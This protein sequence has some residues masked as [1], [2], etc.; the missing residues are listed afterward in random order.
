[1]PEDI[2]LN[3]DEKKVLSEYLEGFGAQVPEEKHTLHTF[4]YRVATSEDTT[5]TGYLERDELG[6]AEYPVRSLKSFSLWSDKVI[7]NDYLKDYFNKESE[8]VTSSSLSRDGFLD[9]LAVTTKQELADI[10]KP[11][12]VNKGWFRKK[13]EETT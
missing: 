4:L 3:E 6:N 10:T 7:V 9:K 8:I 13:P 2:S 1:M 12:S 5:K 11:K